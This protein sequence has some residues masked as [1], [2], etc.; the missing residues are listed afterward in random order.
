M[1]WGV[2]YVWLVDPASRTP[3]ICDGSLR[4]VPKA[5]LREF[6]LEIVPEQIFE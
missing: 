4:D 6:G 2:K 1:E 5:V 3:S